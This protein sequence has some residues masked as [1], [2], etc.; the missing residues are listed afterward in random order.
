MAPIIETV[1][2]I[3]VAWLLSLVPRLVEF[4]GPEEG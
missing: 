2:G 3:T 1:L 4:Q